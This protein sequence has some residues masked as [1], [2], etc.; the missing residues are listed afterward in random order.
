M[1]HITICRWWPGVSDTE[2][3]STYVWIPRSFVQFN[4]P[5]LI[6]QVRYRAVLYVD[7]VLQDVWDPSWVELP[8]KIRTANILSRSGTTLDDV[9]VPGVLVA[10]K[11]NTRKRVTMS[12]QPGV[13]ELS[14]GETI[15]A[16]G[17][18]GRDIIGFSTSCCVHIAW[19]A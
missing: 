13:S 6:A 15:V 14:A 11:S 8:N 12:K 5:S 10:R 17:L 16:Y 19:E 3:L 9:A 2:R 1:I 4:Q 7:E 18:V